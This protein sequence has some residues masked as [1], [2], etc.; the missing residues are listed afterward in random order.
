MISG[1]VFWNFFINLTN[2]KNGE[3]KIVNSDRGLNAKL[4]LIIHTVEIFFLG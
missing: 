4:S 3:V 1:F 2:V